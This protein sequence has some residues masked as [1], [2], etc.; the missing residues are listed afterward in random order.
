MHLCRT[1]LKLAY[2]K[3]GDL[4]SRDHSTVMASVKH[5]QKSLDEDNHEVTGAWHSI[6]KNF[7]IN[8]SIFGYTEA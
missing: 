6:T 3:I 4:F 5:V 7:N 2:M 8:F 1:K